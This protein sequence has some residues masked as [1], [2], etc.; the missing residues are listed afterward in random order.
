MK[1]EVLE[2]T[3]RF[4]TFIPDISTQ[5]PGMTLPRI[6]WVRLNCLR[7]GVASFRFCLHKWDMAPSA[8]CQFGAE[9]QTADNVVLQCPIHLPPH[10]VH[11]LTVLDDET[12]EWL[13]NTC[14]PRCSA[15]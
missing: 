10:G 3:T 7:T 2:N 1:C 13:L 9:E 4:R 12:I 11:G 5:P 8:A 15:A 14:A 6:A